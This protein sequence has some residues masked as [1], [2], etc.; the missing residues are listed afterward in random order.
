MI[1]P[2]LQAARQDPHDGAV[3][4]MT[5]EQAFHILQAALTPTVTAQRVPLADAAG[6]VLAEAVIASH[7]LPPHNSAALDGYAVRRTD[8]LPD[9]PA[10][11]AVIGTAAAGRPY[12]KPVPSGCAVRIFTGAPMPEGT[13]VLLKQEI[14]RAEGG[15]VFVPYASPLTTNFRL[16]GED[17]VIGSTVMETGQRLR[18]Q[19][20][21]MLAALGHAS[22]TVYRRLRVAIFSTGDELCEPGTALASGQICDANRYFLR[23]FLDRIGCTVTDL[24]ILPDDP[25][26]L[27][28]SL[29]EAAASHDLLVTSGGMSVGSEDHLRGVI[30]RRGTIDFWRLA[31]RP[32]R[33]VGLGDIDT[34]PIL[35]LPGNPV[36]AAVAMTVFGRRVIARLGGEYRWQMP[37]LTMPADFTY[38]KPPGRRD[39]LLARYG[40]RR[41]GTTTVR[42][43]P[44]QGAAMLSGLLLADGL[45]EIGE[46]SAHVRP[47]MMVGLIPFSEL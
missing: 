40:Q 38:Q 26:R 11:L 24:G 9:Q 47:G 37:L 44:G 4:A 1:A 19:H 27:E 34:C 42:L 43:V 25:L 20:L 15:A 6:C 33:P 41:S 16:C 5:A 32:G 22:V 12:G 14:C 31:I 17:V 35:A 13:D 18:S 21:P 30:R 2:A 3:R 10:R 28:R 7:N 8:L 45:V 23:G 36:A 39:Y 29:M 46:D